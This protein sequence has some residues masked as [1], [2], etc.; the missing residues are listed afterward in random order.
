MTDDRKGAAAPAKQQRHLAQSL[1]TEACFVVDCS[2]SFS[3]LVSSVGVG[4]RAK[5]AQIVWLPLLSL[6][7]PSLISQPTFC[8]LGG[9]A[10]FH[11]IKFMETNVRSFSV[12]IDYIMSQQEIKLAHIHMTTFSRFTRKA[13]KQEHC[14]LCDRHMCSNSM[15]HLVSF[16]QR[17]QTQ[18]S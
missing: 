14:T 8:F 1:L 11:H 12:I 6:S 15:A 4:T 10:S 17:K 13:Q 18:P 7:L 3:S 5:N 2:P 16:L 9:S